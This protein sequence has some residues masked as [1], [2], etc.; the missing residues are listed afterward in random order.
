ML[1]RIFQCCALCAKWLQYYWIGEFCLVR[2]RVVWFQS[3]IARDKWCRKQ[4]LLRSRERHGLQEYV[5]PWVLW[6]S[7]PLLR[8]C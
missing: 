4:V 5:C 7:L 2:Q 8:I 6:R 1:L 3:A